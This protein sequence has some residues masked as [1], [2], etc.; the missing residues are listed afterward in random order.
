LAVAALDRPLLG[1]RQ[2]LGGEDARRALM[3]AVLEADR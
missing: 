3:A 2:A 1:E